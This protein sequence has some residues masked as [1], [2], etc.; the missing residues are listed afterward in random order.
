MTAEQLKEL[1]AQASGV[2]EKV[3][4]EEKSLQ[5]WNPRTVAGK[6]VKSGEI[7]K[8]EDVWG[9]HLALLEP[10]IIDMLV[11]N[12]DE[13]VIDTR[14]TAYVRA[15]GRRFNYSAF[16]LV[17]DKQNYIGFGMGSD[18]ERYPAIR[19]AVRNAKLN[20]IPVRV[21]AGSWQDF[22]DT[23]RSVPFKVTGKCSSVRVTLHPAPKGTGLVVGKHILDVFQFA[24]I[25]DVW[26]QTRGSSDTKLNFV[27]AA[28]NALE[29]LNKIRLSPDMERKFSRKAGG[30]N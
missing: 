16:V 5:D 7:T 30:V 10:E 3:T 2:G 21:G 19:K 11:P 28:Y 18:K 12:L 26:T 1:E 27:R 15:A 9:R 25:T 24:G 4:H 8:M 17:G 29:Q 13:K 23:T 20:L 22:S 14:K 6:L